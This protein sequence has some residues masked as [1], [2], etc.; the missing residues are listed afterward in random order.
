MKLYEMKQDGFI[1]LRPSGQLTS[2]NA[3][4]FDNEIRSRI[5]SKDSRVIIDLSDLNYISSAGLRVL[6]VLA[7]FLKDG[8]GTLAVCSMNNTISQVF[9]VTGFS[10]VMETYPT[11][12]EAIAEG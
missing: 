1:I 10:S 12:N 2:A 5:N 7:R 3:G 8:E 4:E 6:L 11:L 9:E